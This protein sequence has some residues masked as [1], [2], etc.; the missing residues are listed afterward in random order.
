MVVEAGVE[1]ELKV[2]SAVVQVEE[3]LVAQVELVHSIFESVIWEVHCIS[4][5][6]LGIMVVLLTGAE[7]VDSVLSR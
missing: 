7:G 1:E 5:S 6:L 2:L 3:V 4:S